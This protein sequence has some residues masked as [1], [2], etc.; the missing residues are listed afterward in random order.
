MSGDLRLLSMA[1]LWVAPFAVRDWLGP[2][3]AGICR[4]NAWALW[5]VLRG[6]ALPGAGNLPPS[7]I[8]LRRLIY[9]GIVGD[10]GLWELVEELS[11]TVEDFASAGLWAATVILLLHVMAGVPAWFRAMAIALCLADLGVDFLGY[12]PSAGRVLVALPGLA[13]MVMILIGQRRDGRWSR[14]TIGIG[15]ISEVGIASRTGRLVV[16]RYPEDGD[17]G[18]L[19]PLPDLAEGPGH[20]RMRVYARDNDPDAPGEE[21]LIVVY[22]GRSTKKITHVP[23]S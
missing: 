13:C 21:H 4:L 18:A 19:G 8:W 22:P 5:Q 9:A 23:R 7:V 6:P 12:L 2:I 11:D 16:E 1:T 17:S 20:Y 10:L 15:Q 3:F 14:A